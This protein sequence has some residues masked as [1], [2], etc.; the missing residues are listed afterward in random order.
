[1]EIVDAY[2]TTKP[3]VATTYFQRKTKVGNPLQ[4]IK[5]NPPKMLVV[6]KLICGKVVGY[7]KS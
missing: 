2:I 6:A 7:Q 3:N 1:M 5:L 4:H